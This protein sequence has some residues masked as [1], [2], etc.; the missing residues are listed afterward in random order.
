MTTGFLTLIEKPAELVLT[1]DKV[2]EHLRIDHD[3]EDGYLESLIVSATDEI[4]GKNGWLGRALITQKWCLNLPSFPREVNLPLAP[5]QQV[6]SVQYLAPDGNLKTLDA[7]FYYAVSSEP[8]ELVF[9]RTPTDVV[10]R[11]D[12]VRITYTCG[13]G[14]R[15]KLVPE[16]IKQYL[17]IQ[18]GDLY[19]NRE[20]VTDQP[21][22]ANM[23]N[24]YRV[25]S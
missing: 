24:S 8:A 13:Y 9:L 6:D 3:E 16:K 14:N 17:L 12:A 20:T 2:R 5:L 25:F 11:K 22:I 21:H 18:I 15:S 19:N 4:D 7:N 23:L 1:V 10:S